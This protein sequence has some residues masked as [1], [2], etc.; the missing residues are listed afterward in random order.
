MASLWKVP[1][2]LADALFYH[3]SCTQPTVPASQD[4]Q[5]RTHSTAH[6]TGHWFDGL[7]TSILPSWNKVMFWAFAITET[8]A[9]LTS[10]FAVDESS[11]NFVAESNPSG[12]RIT[13][14]FLLGTALI[15]AGATIRIRCFRE[16]GRHFTFALSLRDDHTLITSGPYAVVR[17]PSYTGG[18][19]SVLGAVLTLMSDGSWW[20]GGGRATLWG[21][22][23]AVN[24]IVC[25]IL[26]VRVFLR[27]GREDVYLKK[28]FGEQWVQFAKKVPYMYIPG[29]W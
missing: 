24:F 26:R 1:F 4:E 8:S 22:F 17:H 2:L 27:G 11:D 13:A 6:P 29:V 9:I 7:M 16:M 21:R 10:Y 28:A 5:K 12:G 3:R 14:V 20:F 25:S 19:M 18:N 15:V 23:L